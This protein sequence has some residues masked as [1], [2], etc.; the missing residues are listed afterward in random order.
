M[1]YEMREAYG[2]DI[3]TE[4]RWINLK[5]KEHLDLLNADRG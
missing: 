4:Y 2:R 1:E 5:E 3:H